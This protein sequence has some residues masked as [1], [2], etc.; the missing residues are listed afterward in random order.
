MPADA[1][2]PARGAGP[3]ITRR[4]LVRILAVAERLVGAFEG[5]DDMLGQEAVG[6]E[7][8]EDRGV[9]RG[10]AR[11]RGARERGTGLGTDRTVVRVQLG[12]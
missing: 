2:P 10:G 1:V 4:L 7:P 6:L 5:D 12:Q 3:P 9:V 11:E 8:L